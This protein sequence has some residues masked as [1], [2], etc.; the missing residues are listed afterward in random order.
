M[1]GNVQYCA[2]VRLRDGLLLASHRGAGES[3]DGTDA[4]SE[5]FQR[6]AVARN[7]R[8][9]VEVAYPDRQG[10]RKCLHVATGETDA[11]A[12]LTPDTYPKG[13][14]LRL[15]SSIRGHIDKD[16]R[17]A[18]LVERAVREEALSKRV[19]PLMQQECARYEDPAEA[20]KVADVLQQ[21]E[22]VKVI[23]AGNIDKVLDQT[24][25]LETMESKGGHL[26]EEAA[27]FQ[28]SSEEAK[29]NIYRRNCRIKIIVGVIIALL[30][31][32]VII[33]ICVHFT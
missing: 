21:V 17:V 22:E 19:G 18:E 14:A 23:I 7:K 16:P 8:L 9:A 26:M 2:Y 3:G 29:R 24:P 28:K 32:Y 15:L 25:N 1:E 27:I 5:V 33:P 13:V 10:A 6:G 12:V 11:L 20:A 31:L 30:V 4:V